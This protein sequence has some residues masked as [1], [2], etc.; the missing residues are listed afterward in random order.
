MSSE[1][2]IFFRLDLLVC[3]QAILPHK[4]GLICKLHLVLAVSI[5]CSGS[6]VLAISNRAYIFENGARF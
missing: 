1:Y 6:M 5:Y 3:T 2:E 4:K